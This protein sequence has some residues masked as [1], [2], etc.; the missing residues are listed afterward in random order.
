MHALRHRSLAPQVDFDSVHEIS[1]RMSSSCRSLPVRNDL[2]VSQVPTYFLRGHYSPTRPAVVNTATTGRLRER[3]LA[4]HGWGRHPGIRNCAT[5]TRGAGKRIPAGVNVG[6]NFFEACFP[7]Y[8]F[9][10]RLPQGSDRDYCNQRR[11]EAANTK[12]STAS[13]RS[14]KPWSPYPVAHRQSR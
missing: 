8:A 4:N 12:A 11:A 3:S 14:T 13:L 7:S 10:L 1:V 9:G 2:P 6:E 5:R